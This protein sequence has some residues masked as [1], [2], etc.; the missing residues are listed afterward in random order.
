MLAYVF[1]HWRQRRVTAPDYEARLCRFHAALAE[2]PPDGFR[3]SF[4]LGLLGAPWA[5]GGGEAYEDWYLLDSSAD[6]D[7]LNEAAVTTSRRVPHDDAA[8]AAEGGTAGLYRLRMGTPIVAPGATQWFSKP[9]AVSY[10]ALYEQLRS[11]V[12]STGGALWG[13]QMTLGP[14]RE[15]CLHVPHAVRLP[16]ELA[17]LAVSTCTVFPRSAREVSFHP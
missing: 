9:P 3:G 1:W 7:R 15:F 13:R 14:A 17:A 2:A 11:V 16:D 10:P 12:E 5:N 4:A 8:M 6:L